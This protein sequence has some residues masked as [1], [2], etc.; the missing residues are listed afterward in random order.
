MYQKRKL[1]NSINTSY[2][3]ANNFDLC[4]K[5]FYIDG[6]KLFPSFFP[7]LKV[8]IFLYQIIK[9]RKL[10]V[11][12]FTC[13]LNHEYSYYTF[14]KEQRNQACTIIVDKHLKLMITWGNVINCTF[15]ISKCLTSRQL[16]TYRDRNRIFYVH[17]IVIIVT[18]LSRVGVDE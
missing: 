16:K 5:Y 1:F 2:F 3:H 17:I 14:L 9:Q 10:Q 11:S 18:K 4:H 15:M 6:N 7:K 12:T 8:A 13:W